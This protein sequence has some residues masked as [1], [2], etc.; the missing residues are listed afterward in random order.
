MKEVNENSPAATIGETIKEA[1][2]VVEIYAKPVQITITDPISGVT[3][4]AIL[5][6]NGI[7][8]VPATLFDDY[9]DRPRARTGTAHMTSLD[10]F[11]DHTN[12][13]RDGDSAVFAN[14]SRDMPSLTSVLDYHPDGATSDPRHGRHRGNFAFPLSDEWKA[15]TKLNGEKMSMVD[16][17]LFL[18]D[19]VLDVLDVIPGEDSLGED[20]E[21]YIA[22]AGNPTIATAQRLVQLS[23]GLQVYESSAV[24]EVINLSSGEGQIS[25]QSEHTDA[26]GEPLKVPGLFL[27]AIPVF[28]NGPLYRIAARLRYRKQ[29]GLTFWYDLW[30]VDRTFDH[31]FSEALE[32]VAVETELPVFRGR[33]E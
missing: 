14:D 32:R 33:P 23:R 26:N 7:H 29:G 15:W 1:L 22:A 16:F 25:F 30:R 27:I 5:H 11:I 9:L 2:S 31:A 18:D 20:L 13:F 19:R 10:S 3:A 4:P 12:R 6:P 24:R 17:A 28:K 21:K 8:G